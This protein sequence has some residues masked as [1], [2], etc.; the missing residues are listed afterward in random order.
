MAMFK[1]QLLQKGRVKGTG[2]RDWSF[3][4]FLCK[5]HCLHPWWCFDLLTRELEKSLALSDIFWLQKWIGRSL[6]PFLWM[7]LQ[8]DYQ[9]KVIRARESLPKFRLTSLSTGIFSMS[10]A[11]EITAL[12]H[13]F[14]PLFCTLPTISLLLAVANIPDVWASSLFCCFSFP[15][16]SA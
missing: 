4:P 13:T 1:Q 2:G 10:V 16:S 9:S 15:D 5:Y 3:P 14:L 11:S 7:L 6:I 12:F 8:I